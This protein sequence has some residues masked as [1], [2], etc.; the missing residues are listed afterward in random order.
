MRTPAETPIEKLNFWSRSEREHQRVREACLD[1]LDEARAN[2]GALELRMDEDIHEA[3]IINA[4]TH[5]SGKA[6]EARTVE[7]ERVRNTP[8]KRELHVLWE[9]RLPS[10][11]LEKGRCLFP[12]DQGCVGV[13]EHGVS[14]AKERRLVYPRVKYIGGQL[15]VC[16]CRIGGP[17]RVWFAA[18]LGGGFLVVAPPELVGGIP[19]GV[20][21]VKNATLTR[22]GRW[23][24]TMYGQR[25]HQENVPRCS[26]AS[27]ERVGRR[28]AELV[29]RDDA[30]LM[31]SRSQLKRAR[32]GGRGI[33]MQT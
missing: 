11:E 26:N 20:H 32:F 24:R 28:C 8:R 18:L 2:P 9:A 16:R 17:T 15:C 12:R 5:R 21:H 10:D 7:S 30:A 19:I 31:A 23:R 6:D 33:E 1:T 29:F 4:I 13:N 14:V 3:G 25:T 27:D 22:D